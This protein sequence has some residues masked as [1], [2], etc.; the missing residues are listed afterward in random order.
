MKEAQIP[1]AADE[2]GSRTYRVLR[3]CLIAAVAIGSVAAF[4]VSIVLAV[5]YST[6]AIRVANL[7]ELPSISRITDSKAAVE[8]VYV[9]ILSP[10]SERICVIGQVENEEELMR[11]FPFLAD[12]KAYPGAD[13]LHGRIPEWLLDAVGDREPFVPSD[14]SWHVSV[15]GRNGRKETDASVAFSESSNRF[16]LEYI[17]RF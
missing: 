3:G 12:A 10:H 13:S 1:H 16:Y 6:P 4:C 17:W 5:G 11:L 7:E 8:C 2:C 9:K 15:P 14:R